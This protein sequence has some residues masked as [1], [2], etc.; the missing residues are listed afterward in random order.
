MSTVVVI[1]AVLAVA[2]GVGVISARVPVHSVLALILTLVA[3]AVLFIAAGAE[4]MGL[5][6]V[7]VYAGAVMVMFVFV[8]SLLTARREPVERPQSLLPRQERA[9]YVVG[10][11]LA[12]V[13]IA[14][15]LQHAY[16]APAPLPAGYGTV[17]AFGTALFQEH[18]FVLQLAALLLM[19]AAIGVV[20]VMARRD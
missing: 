17:R 11:A 8:I 14:A 1:A 15:V 13:L 4:Y 12:A 16:P 9:G 19:A 6:Q 10:A 7:I 5:L 18:V 2:G 20:I 3:L